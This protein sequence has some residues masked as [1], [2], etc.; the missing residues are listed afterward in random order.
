M[1]TVVLQRICSMAKGLIACVPEWVSMRTPPHPP[2]LPPMEHFQSFYRKYRHRIHIYP[3]SASTCELDLDYFFFDLETSVVNG[4]VDRHSAPTYILSTFLQ[5][6]ADLFV[7]HV[8]K[9]ARPDAIY[10]TRIFHPTDFEQYVSGRYDPST[11]EHLSYALVIYHFLHH[12]AQASTLILLPLDMDDNNMSTYDLQSY[13]DMFTTSTYD[14]GLLPSHKSRMPVMYKRSFLEARFHD[15]VWCSCASTMHCVS[16]L[17]RVDDANVCT[18]VSAS[19]VD[20][21]LS[22]H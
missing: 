22:M 18:Y 8:P 9:L 14:L 3:V 19:L 16:M 1:Y 20:M 21:N 7:R 10:R 15:D 5:S 17:Q 2:S 4:M 6:W 11:C 13:V 12:H